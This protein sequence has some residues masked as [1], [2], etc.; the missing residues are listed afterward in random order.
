MCLRY[1]DPRVKTLVED[2]L[3]PA[4]RLH[5]SVLGCAAYRHVRHLAV[6]SLGVNGAETL[7]LVYGVCPLPA[8]MKCAN[9]MKPATCQMS[10][11]DLKFVREAVAEMRPR[12]VLSGVMYVEG[13]LPPQSKGEWRGVR[14]PPIATMTLDVWVYVKD[15]CMPIRLPLI[16]AIQDDVQVEVVFRQPITCA[17]LGFSM[18]DTDIKYER[19]HHGVGRFVSHPRPHEKLYIVRGE[20]LVYRAKDVVDCPGAKDLAVG[21]PFQPQLPAFLDHLRAQQTPSKGGVARGSR[22]ASSAS[23]ALSSTSVLA[24]DFD[25]SIA[26]PARVLRS[27]LILPDNDSPSSSRTLTSTSTNTQRVNVDAAE[28]PD[29]LVMARSIPSDDNP[30]VS[31]DDDAVVESNKEILSR[32]AQ[33]RVKR[34]KKANVSDSEATRSTWKNGPFE[35]AMYERL[36]GWK[37]RKQSER[38][39][40]VRETEARLL[41]IA[42]WDQPTPIL[43]AMTN[44]FRNHRRDSLEKWLEREAE[45]AMKENQTGTTLFK[46]PRR[47]AASELWAK[48]NKEYILENVDSDVENGIGGHFASVRSVLFKDEGEDVRDHYEKLANAPPPDA[49]IEKIMDKNKCLLPAKVSEMLESAQGRGV[50]KCGHFTYHCRIGWRDSVGRL[51]SVQLCGGH[52]DGEKDFIKHM[53][54]KLEKESMEFMTWSGRTLPKTHIGMDVGLTY[55]EDGTPMLPNEDDSSWNAP[56]MGE[57]LWLYF[58]A[59][60]EH[61]FGDLDAPPLTPALVSQQLKALEWPD[62][63]FT[64]LEVLKACQVYPLWDKVVEAQKTD[65]PFIFDEDVLHKAVDNNTHELQIDEDMPDE[66]AMVVEP[67]RDPIGRTDRDRGEVIGDRDQRHSDCGD[68][69]RN[70]D[71]PDAAADHRA[72]D[73]SEARGSREPDPRDAADRRERDQRDG[74]VARRGGSQRDRE[75]REAS[76][77]DGRDPR[78]A[79]DPRERDQRDVEVDRR[80][81]TQ[82]DRDQREARVAD[83]RDRNPR[84]AADRRDRDARDTAADLDIDEAGSSGTPKRRRKAGSDADDSDREDEGDLRAAKRARRDGH[85]DSPESSKA[86]D[87]SI[88]A[89]NG[90]GSKR[91]KKQQ[92]KPKSNTSRPSSTSDRQTRAT[93]KALAEQIDSEDA[94][95]DADPRVRFKTGILMSKHPSVKQQSIPSIVEKHNAPSFTKALNH[96]VYNMKLGHPLTNREAAEASSYLPFS[97]LDIFHGFKFTTIPLSDGAAERDAVKAKPAVGSQPARFDT[98]VVLQGDDAEATG[99]QGTRI[100]RVRV[101]FRLPDKIAEYG[102]NCTMPAPEE[103]AEHGPLASRYKKLLSTHGYPT[104]IVM[105]HVYPSM[106]PASKIRNAHDLRMLYSTISPNGNIIFTGVG[107]ENLKFWRA[108]RTLKAEKGKDEGGS[109]KGTG[110]TSRSILG[111]R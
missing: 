3:P 52:P 107:N 109:Q 54:G 102:S 82:R 50:H 78:D 75:D 15:G 76:V 90:K 81:R 88:D 111:I 27:G 14:H 56:K 61:V 39:L 12:A 11:V 98:V 53:E 37:S 66:H 34:A 83:D 68:D 77:A 46:K 69:A 96:Y 110:S 74:E 70:L 100:G 71:L 60:W 22:T 17:V 26:S 47:L 62:V 23:P 104:D 67:R 21:R 95:Q 57:V 25:V 35:R 19:F 94:I 42:D 58:T 28:N 41:S 6:A 65:E 2:A 51:H 1:G 85:E 89:S 92:P 64:N 44:W 40:Y 29:C 97:R 87:G 30:L 20:H 36:A 105:V 79:A 4:L 43:Q 80:G 99:L 93:A 72:R 108:W 5:D 13:E 49:D 33:R 91:G 101:I 18:A 31:E 8:G 48:D 63:D 10:D 84:D 9:H 59:V 73:H 103:W 55:Q 106:K 32:K 38:P 7:G 86:I 16:C 24:D 45:A